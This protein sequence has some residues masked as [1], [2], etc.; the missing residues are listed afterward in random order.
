[1]DLSTEEQ[2]TGDRDR[3]EVAWTTVSNPRRVRV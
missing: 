3:D 1:M 2:Q